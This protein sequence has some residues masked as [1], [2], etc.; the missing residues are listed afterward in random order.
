MVAMPVGLEAELTAALGAF[1][2]VT[3]FS[4]SFMGEP[5]IDASSVSTAA[6]W[7]GAPTEANPEQRLA[8][9]LQACLYERCYAHR[10][11]DVPAQRDREV[12]V[13]DADFARRFAEA[14][15]SRERWDPGWMIYQ[16]GA[17]G[18]VFV[19]KGERE[20]I[21]MPGAFISDLVLGQALQIGASVR[22]RAPREATGVQ[23]GYYFAFGE[24]LDEAAEQLSLVRFYFHC[25]AENAARLLG[26]LS[27]ALNRFQVPF[28]VKAPISPALYGRTDAVVLYIAARFFAIVARTVSSLPE[29]EPLAPSTPLFTKQLWPG[30]GVAV[31]PGT[32][33]SFGS[34]RCRLCA[35]GI[36][37]AWREGKQDAA[38]RLTAAAARFAAAG[39][40]IMRP[41]LGSG[42]VDVFSLP[43]SPRLP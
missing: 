30:I 36:V 38:A 32:G 35:E 21:A 42:W 14:N 37:D 28:Q 29:S 39:L 16:L 23:P 7:T 4:F 33:E 34:H 20:R 24:T 27:S 19:R 26:A 1:N 8:R 25:A 31:D 5:A 6:G 13:E 12:P 3:P 40:D 43:A 17:S 11:G 9:A 41:Y 22:L 15:T 10:L 18:Q 2:I